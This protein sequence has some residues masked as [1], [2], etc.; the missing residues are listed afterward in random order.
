M[1]PLFS[2][3][4]IREIDEYAIMELGMPGLLL[5]ENASLSIFDSIIEKI[6]YYPE[7]KKIGIV[8]GKGNNGGDGFACARHFANA[9]FNVSVL[10]IGDEEGMSP[11]CLANFKILS[12]ISKQSENLF[13]KKYT[14]VKDLRYVSD[15]G[16]ILDAMLGSGGKGELRE[17]FSELVKNLNSIKS[18]KVAVDIPTGVDADTGSASEAFRADM[19]VTLGEFKKGLFFGAGFIQSGIVTKGDIGVGFSHFDK[20]ET[21]DY[22]IEPEDVYRCLPK[23]KKDAHKYSA[24]KVYVIAGSG[25]LPGAAA[26]T[27]KSALKVGAGAAVLAFPKSARKLIGKK[28]AEVVVSAYNDDGKEFL[29]SDNLGEI[30][31]RLKWADVLAVGPGLGREEVTQAAVREII[32]NRKCSKMVIDAD[33]I[34]ALSGEAFRNLDLRDLILTPHHGE[35]ANL[36]GVD[37]KILE[38]D[39][40]F[41]GK[42]FVSKTG[43][44]LVLKGAPTIIFTPGGDAVINSAGNPGM[45]KFGTGDVLTGTIAGFLSQSKSIEDAVFAGVY[46]HSLA[47]DL[48]LK[49]YTEFGYTATDII[50]KLPSA[51]KF[52]RNSFA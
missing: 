35:F 27:S 17:P 36:I 43:S 22:L 32:K 3:A 19:T 44:Y 11:D 10:Y 4:Q 24:G 50:N 52:L 23:K 49:D 20:F 31:S 46:L 16:V 18:F 25:A 41:F 2:T 37:V 1:I 40:L 38:D 5:M 7:S 48:L 51:I 33:A 9:G 12:N 29:S 21:N 39:L 30:E 42:D 13:I 15:C 6:G 45:A 26:L 28:L 47:A 8:C 34:Y 14:S